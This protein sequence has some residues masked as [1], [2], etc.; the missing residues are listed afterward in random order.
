MDPEAV[1]TLSSPASYSWVDASQLPHT[2]Y[3]IED[4]NVAIARAFQEHRPAALAGPARAAL[5]VLQYQ[6]T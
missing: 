2:W 4:C 1:R 6:Y 5:L 3:V